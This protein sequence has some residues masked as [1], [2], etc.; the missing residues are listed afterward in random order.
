M[1][2]PKYSSEFKIMIAEAYL[3]GE[4]GNVLRRTIPGTDEECLET[5]FCYHLKDRLSHRINPSGAI[6]HCLYDRNNKLVEEISPYSCEPEGLVFVGGQYYINLPKSII[7]AIAFLLESRFNN[8]IPKD[9]RDFL[10]V[11]KIVFLFII[12]Y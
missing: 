10:L 11:G 2:K 12:L 1:S 7:M 4:G 8:N 5:G 9:L 6:M 3:N